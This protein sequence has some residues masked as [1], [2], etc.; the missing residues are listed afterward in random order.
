[1]QSIRVRLA[2]SYALALTA[3]MAIFGAA[4][5]WERTAAAPREA[6]RVLDERLADQATRVTD[7]LRQQARVSRVGR[8]RE[9]DTLRALVDSSR[10]YF[11]ETG[12]EI[13]IGDETG[14]VVYVSPAAQALSD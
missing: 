2:V 5:Y 12:D 13:V 7:L 10:T 6:E 14:R 3:T 9:A 8:V 1:M 4:V 11:D